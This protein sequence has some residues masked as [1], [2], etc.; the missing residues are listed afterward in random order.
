M[1]AAVRCMGRALIHHQRH[2]LSK[3]VYQTSLCSCVVNIQV[4]NRHFAAATKSAKKTKK[5]AKEK[6]LDEKKD[7]IEK[8]KAYPYMEGEPED[9]VYLKRLYPRQIYEVEKAVHLL[10]KFQILDFTSP[11]QS[12]YLDLTLDMALGKKNASEVKIAEENGAAFAGGT[13]LIQKIWDDEIVADFYIA[14]PEIMP[15]LSRL[16]KKLNKR[17]P[18]LSRNSIGRDIPKMLELFKNGHEIKV[19]EERENF[20]QTKIAT[21][22]M[23]SDQIAANLQV[24]INEVCRHRPLNLGPFVVRAFL[25]SSTSEGLLLKIDPLLPKEVKNEESKKEDA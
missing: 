22:D 23:S 2:S 6:T 5:G 19:D 18:K 10:K 17:Y 4:P 21:L 24:V 14:V 7:E 3:M 13:S 1:A 16:R 8:I 9:D 11:K 20:L 12:V 25:R 15:E